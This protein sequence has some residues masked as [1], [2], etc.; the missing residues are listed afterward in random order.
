MKAQHLGER[1]M[2]SATKILRF[3]L[4]PKVSHPWYDEVRQGALAQ[5]ELLSNE[6]LRIDIEYQAPP[7]TQHGTQRR[8]LS[9]AATHPPSGLA[10]DPI[11]SP[12]QIAELRALQDMGVPIVLFDAPTAHSGLCA[13][14]NDFYEQGS[15]AAEHLIREINGRG[16]VAIMKGVPT[17]PNHQ[18]RYE[19]QYAAL[20]R[21]PGIVIVE[22]G[23]DYDDIDLAEQ[24]AERTL[25]THQDLR[26]YLCCDAAGPVGIAAAIRRRGIAHQVVAVTMDSIRPILEAIRDGVIRASS[27]TRPRLQGALAVNM[28]WLASQGCQLPKQIDTGIDL[29]TSE[30]VHAFIAQLDAEGT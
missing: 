24:E 21:H 8:I 9:A 4:V 1:T 30:N 15:V 22:G 10:I 17:A 27:A 18:Q 14:G 26:G 28:L 20:S 5:A 19:A 23:T 29:V 3:I 16:K 11:E 25:S 6:H 2:K 13:V 7:N 12:I